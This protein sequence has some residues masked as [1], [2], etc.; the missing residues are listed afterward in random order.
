MRHWGRNETNRDLVDYIGVIT[1]LELLF[2]KHY[3]NGKMVLAH[4]IT[5]VYG[6]L[7]R[8]VKL[9]YPEYRHR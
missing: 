9:T 5:M 4:D 8:A 2:N 1:K 6:K 3:W 7:L